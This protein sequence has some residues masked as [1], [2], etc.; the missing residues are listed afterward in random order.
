MAVLL[1]RDVS[2]LNWTVVS[3]ERGRDLFENHNSRN[4]FKIMEV[5]ED[6]V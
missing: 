1:A 6:N 2:C 5:L 4:F 3:G